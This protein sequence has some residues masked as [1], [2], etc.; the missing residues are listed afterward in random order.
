MENLIDRDIIRNHIE[1]IILH[2]LTE[3]DRYGYEIC[4]TVWVRSGGTY[5]LKEPSLYSAFRRLENAQLVASYWGDDAS[6][7]ARRKY[8]RITQA[9]TEYYRHTVKEWHKVKELID[10]LIGEEDYTKRKEE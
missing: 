1:T 7:G 3:Q 4:K 9:G 2:E 8:Y 5:E 6:K 10:T